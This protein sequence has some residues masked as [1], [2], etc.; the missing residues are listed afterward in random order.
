M[1][2]RSLRARAGGDGTEH[3]VTFAFFDTLVA[4]DRVEEGRPLSQRVLAAKR[5]PATT[6]NQ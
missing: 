3:T 2:A 5:R 4:T 6:L 1:C